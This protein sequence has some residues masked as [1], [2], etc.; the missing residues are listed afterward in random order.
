VLFY[1]YLCSLRSLILSLYGTY[2]VQVGI[3]NYPTSTCYTQGV[4]QHDF[5]VLKLEPQKTSKSTLGGCASFIGFVQEPPAFSAI[6]WQGTCSDAMKHRVVLLKVPPN[7]E[8]HGGRGVVRDSYEFAGLTSQGQ[9]V[10]IP[11]PT[12]PLAAILQQFAYS[13]ARPAGD[14]RLE[15]T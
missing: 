8:L 1:F 2:S 4:K 15:W 14:R 10:L 5:V 12:P 7:F 9:E 6:L 3:P 13:L 11:A